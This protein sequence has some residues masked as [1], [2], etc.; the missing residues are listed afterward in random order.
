MPAEYEALRLV[1]RF[2]VMALYG[3]PLTRRE[4]RRMIGCEAIIGAYQAMKKSGNFAT[5]SDEHPNESA[6]LAECRALIAAGESRHGMESSD[7]TS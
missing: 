1:D 3:R 4:V 5:W 6:M 2:G 7:A